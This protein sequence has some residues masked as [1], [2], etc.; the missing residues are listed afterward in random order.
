MSPEDAEEFTQS[1]EMIQRG[2]WQQI[3]W[4]AR[5]GIPAALGMTT[6]DWVEQ[7]IGGYARLAIPERREAV[8]ELT[9]EGMTQ[10]EVADVLGVSKTTIVDDLGRFRPAA[11][12]KREVVEP[13]RSELTKEERDALV[14]GHA[15]EDAE[16]E[17][18][19]RQHAYLSE[20]NG[21]RRSIVALAD[22]V[23][24]DH[25]HADEGWVLAVRTAAET[26]TRSVEAIVAN[27]TQPAADNV[28]RIR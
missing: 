16:L 11:D 7:R 1:V 28:R 4:A 26:I 9:A 3:A 20:L 15:T 12:T 24:D 21:L 27:L 17:A 13:P 18:M 19:Q 23:P 10:R 8:A 22:R 5:Q 25:S 14:R 2:S 6:R